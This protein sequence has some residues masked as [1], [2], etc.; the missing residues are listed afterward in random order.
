MWDKRLVAIK[1]GKRL[2]TTLLAHSFKPDFAAVRLLLEKVTRPITNKTNVAGRIYFFI[3]K[4]DFIL[5]QFQHLFDFY[6]NI[7]FWYV[8]CYNFRAD[9]LSQ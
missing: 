7:C 8:Y 1:K 6:G 9:W 4:T 5:S 3:E 2:G